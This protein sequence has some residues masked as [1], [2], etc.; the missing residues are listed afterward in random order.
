MYRF[1]LLLALLPLLAPPAARAQEN[2]ELAGSVDRYVQPLVDLDVFSGVV[3]VARGDSVV[4]ARAYGLADR[5]FGVPNAV[6]SAFR[7]ASISKSFTRVLVGRL[8]DR[9]VL[10][11]DDPLSRWLP[12]FP[13]ADRITIRLLLDHRAGVPSVNSLPFDEEAFAPHSL[14]GLVDSIARMPL[15]FEPG[16]DESYSN[17]GYA[18]L[19]LAL[20]R[21]TGTSYPSLLE[22]EVL[23]PLGLA[24]TAHERDGDVVP[25]LARGYEPGPETFRRMRHAPFQEMMT[26]TGGG[27]LVS[28]AEDLHR[29][30]RALGRDPI[31]RLSTWAELFPDDDFDLSG[32]CPGYNAYLKREGE[33]VA[34]V[35][36][37]NYAAGAV[38]NVAAAGIRLAAGRPADP[39]PVTAP[40]AVPARDL[41]PFA[42]AYALP[43]GVLPLPPGTRVVVAPAGDDL[44]ATL[45][46]TPVDVL[47]PQGRRTFLLRALW[48]TATF[49]PPVDGRSP[50]F[51]VRALYRDASFRAERVE[52]ARP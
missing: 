39:L 51:E 41:E 8:V 29:W 23:A 9:G 10:A 17:G 12:D 7:I 50:G 19:A 47:V 26:K 5:E 30:G 46:G 4:L 31:L 24:R 6:D 33:W 11:L 27:S 44:V 36:A 28:T 18:V 34:I 22:T 32:R 2:S 43:D 14:T 15:D 16:T 1:S 48:S 25:R 49:D 3:L 37:N 45:A 40:V 52:G 35:L 13:S 20:E 21:A 38:G 42:G